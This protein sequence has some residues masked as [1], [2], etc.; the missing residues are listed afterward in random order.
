VAD[1][2][3]RTNS[4]IVDGRFMRCP[5]CRVEQDVLAY[6]PMETI[7]EFRSETV[8]VYK[9]PKCRWIFAPTLNALSDIFEREVAG[10]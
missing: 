9:C 1:A 2:K 10:E 3:R 6:I 7:E 8:P 4:L 5:R